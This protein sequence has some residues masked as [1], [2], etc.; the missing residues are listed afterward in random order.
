MSERA[1]PFTK[2][3]SCGNNFVIVDEI[4]ECHI[5]EKNKSLFSLR[6]SD[7]CFG[8]GADGLLVVQPFQADVL[9]DI[10]NTFGYW[11][12]G[13]AVGECDFVFRLFEN[14]GKEALS[15]GNGLLCIAAYLHQRY[16]IDAARIMTEVPL[17]Q[18][19][20]LTVG[21]CQQTLLYWCNM[22]Y[23]RR[24]PST[25][26][27]LPAI[28]GSTPS[29]DFI[30]RL[31]IGFRSHDLQPFSSTQSLSL[32]GYLTFTGEPHLVI[33][34]DEQLPWGLADTLFTSPES[35]GREKR[36][37][38]GSWLVN[39]IG[40]YINKHYR[41]IFPAE[42]NVNFARLD[43]ETGRIQHR[44]YERGVDRETLACGTGAVAVSFVAKHLQRIKRAK[45]VVIPHRCTWYQPG[46]RLWVQ[47][48][49][50]GW[51]LMGNPLQ[52]FTGQSQ[53]V[54]ESTQLWN[55][56]GTKRGSPHGGDDIP[57]MKLTQAMN[58]PRPVTQKSV[59]ED[60]P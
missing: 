50:E 29:L 55:A 49:A 21:R 60:V 37:N 54:A 39:H 16:G 7:T 18:P 36:W 34:P 31:E 26:V 3:T 27:S 33:F 10:N 12:T 17:S 56:P 58:R 40:A 8:I 14:N 59:S 57:T 22:G 47:E 20:A 25:L 48:T 23:P 30:D 45:I 1:I 28:A 24:I 5:E 35:S 13:P 44:C 42:V 19:S 51:L 53:L 41:H 52:L 38:F 15:C 11:D 4:S 43:P 9:R 6:A 46:A 32:A 2:Y